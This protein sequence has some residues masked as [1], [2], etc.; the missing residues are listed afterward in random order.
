VLATCLVR[1]LLI[2]RNRPPTATRNPALKCRTWGDRI[3]CALEDIAL[4][5]LSSKEGQVELVSQL[6][7][8]HRNILNSL[9]VKPP[10]RVQ[11]L[12]ET[13]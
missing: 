2:P 4:V 5:K 3:R 9:S 6:A 10:K 8:E 11:R 1:K 12:A 13:A 7:D